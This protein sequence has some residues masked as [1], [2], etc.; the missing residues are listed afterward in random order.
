MR[1]G[2]FASPTR[3]GKARPGFIGA[4][5]LNRWEGA[6]GGPKRAGESFFHFWEPTHPLMLLI[7]VN[8][9]DQIRAS[10][11]SRALRTVALAGWA[12]SEFAVPV[13][14]ARPDSRTSISRTR[15][16][17]LKLQFF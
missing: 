3:L 16:S 1:L 7:R 9:Y 17:P 10:D 2:G 13:R 6:G 11:G 4:V 15:K 14:R 5:S 8:V 12:T